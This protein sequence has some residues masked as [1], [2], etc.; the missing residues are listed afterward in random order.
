MN[1]T[2]VNIRMDI[3]TKKKAQNIARE[4]GL[5]LSSVVNA[6]LKQ[7]VRTK[8]VFFSLEELP[9]DYFLE[10]LNRSERDIKKGKVS[11]VFNN[12][13]EADEWLDNPKA[14]YANKIHEG[15]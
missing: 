8:S 12:T 14:K 11:P 10:A 9:S 13:E 6:Y 7:F 3:E 1:T 2:A 5:N 4:L 15:V